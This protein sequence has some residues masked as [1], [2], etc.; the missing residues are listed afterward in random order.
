M[1]SLPLEGGCQCEALRYQVSAPP[2][3]VYCCHCT[4]CQKISTSAFAIS[5]IIPEASFAF[6]KG[7]PKRIEW[8]ADSGSQRFGWFCG[9]C[10]SRIAHGQ[11]PSRGFLSLRAGTLDDTSWVRPV[12][13]IWMQ[14]AQS[15]MTFEPDALLCD[16]QPDNY[17]PYAERFRALGLFEY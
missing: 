5:A 4:T 6:T 12:G 1:V 16:V 11:S 3:T 2:L 10:G 7:E 9:D 8:V 13:H 14:S 17:G 15:W